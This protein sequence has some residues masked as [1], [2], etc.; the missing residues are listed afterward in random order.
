MTDT[1]NNR[2]CLEMDKLTRVPP[3]RSES[4]IAVGLEFK[5]ADSGEHLQ[6]EIAKS[7]RFRPPLLDYFLLEVLSIDAELQ[8]LRVKLRVTSNAGEG[9]WLS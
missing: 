2:G 7:Q 8:S 9:A 6:K 1:K 3:M 4:V 5:L